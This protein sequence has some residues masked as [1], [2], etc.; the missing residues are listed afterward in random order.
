[1]PENIFGQIQY[2]VCIKKMNY[3]LTD[4]FNFEP[5]FKHSNFVIISLGINDLSTRKGG[6][7]PFAGTA[8]CLMRNEIHIL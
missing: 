3:Y 5:Q 1:M 8:F 4:L 7:A 6:R 2:H